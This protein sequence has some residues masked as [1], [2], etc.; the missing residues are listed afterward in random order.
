MAFSMGDFGFGLTLAVIGAMLVSF[1]VG[2]V[3]FDRRRPYIHASTGECWGIASIDAVHEDN[4]AADGDTT[5]SKRPKTTSKTTLKKVAECR[6]RDAFDNARHLS[7]VVTWYAIMAALGL[8]AVTGTVGALGLQLGWIQKPKG[9]PAAVS[10][11]G[12]Q[13]VGSLSGGRWKTTRFG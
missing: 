6:A 1:L 13:T 12:L 5:E 2:Y 3:T 11:D 4:D 8:L 9:L 7:M 10:P